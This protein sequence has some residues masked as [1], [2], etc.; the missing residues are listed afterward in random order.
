MKSFMSRNKRGLLS[1]FGGFLIQLVAGSYH[2]TFGNLLPY[3]TSYVR[4][5][6]D[7]ISNGDVAMIFSVGGFAQGLTYLFGGL[8]LVP[9][10]GT[11]MSMIIAAVIFTSGPLLTY[12]CLLANSR[13]EFL[14][15]LYGILSAG[16]NSILILGTTVLSTSW[17]PN[18][19]GKVVGFISGGF[20]LSSTVFT[21]FQTFLVNPNNTDPTRNDL[22]TSSYFTDPNVLDR[23]PRVFLYMGFIY[24]AIFVVGL[25]LCVGKPE[26]KSEDTTMEDSA[27]KRLKA[28]WKFMYQEASRTQNFYLLFLAR[29]LYLAIGA[30]ALAH[31]KTFSFTQ[32]NNDQIISAVGSGCGVFNWLSRVLTGML[33]DKIGY[34]KLMSGIGIL[35]TINL[36]TIPWVGQS[37]PGLMVS[38]W[39]LYLLAFSHFTTIP[40]QALRLY[41]GS[42]SYVAFACISLAETFSYALLAILNKFIMDDDT[43]PKMFMIF[44]LVLAS[45]SL[46]SVP[47]TWFVKENPNK[48]DVSEDKDTQESSL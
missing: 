4:Q 19:R 33:Y 6:D 10:I 34:S 14:W 25:I 17:F 32:N 2:G 41:P 35:L 24:A 28:A 43:N 37:L 31:W 45:C 8:I 15:F 40:A 46:I 44:F 27:V 12:P 21:P 38:I 47:I 1:V 22:T 20:G 36:A 23:I 29:F 9:S 11:R 42:S 13:I 48:N 30:G 18:H 7:E 5:T 26:D 3:L 16:S 39:C